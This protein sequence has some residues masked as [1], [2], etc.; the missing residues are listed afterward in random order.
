M[1]QP[2][3]FARDLPEG[4]VYRPE[5]ISAE[6]ERTLE[7][8]IEQLS[9]AQIKMHGAIAKRRAAH[10]GRGYEYESGRIDTA[11]RSRSSFCHCG[12]ASMSSP[13]GMQKNSPNCS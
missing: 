1:A 2:Q 7:G 8:T 5:F 12:R 10:F 6:E 9:F 13:G 11:P 4:F 3:L